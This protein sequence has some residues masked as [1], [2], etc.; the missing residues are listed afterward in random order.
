MVLLY[1]LGLYFEN[2]N[3]KYQ[4][5]SERSLTYFFE[6]QNKMVLL[7][8]KTKKICVHPFMEIHKML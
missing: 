5:V 3:A 6:A 8:K 1:R 4:A 7:K 2:M